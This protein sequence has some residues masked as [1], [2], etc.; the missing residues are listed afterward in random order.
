LVLGLG[1]SEALTNYI[2]TF[3]ICGFH[4]GGYEECLLDCGAMRDLV[5]IDVSEELVASVFRV[6]EC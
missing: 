4:S 5:R 1:L 3:R 2:I 6:E